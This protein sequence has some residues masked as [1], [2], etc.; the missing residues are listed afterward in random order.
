MDLTAISLVRVPCPA[1]VAVLGWLGLGACAPT[2]DVS[3]VDASH[4]LRQADGLALASVSLGEGTTCAA[5]AT[6]EAKCWGRNDDGRLG[7]GPSSSVVEA[8][9][10]LLPFLAVGGDV[11]AIATNGPHGYALLDDGSVVV[12]GVDPSGAFGAPGEPEGTPGSGV[13]VPL[14]GPAEQVVAGEGFGCARLSDARVQCWG[15][16]D[17]GQLGRGALPG[18]H[19]PADVLLGGVAVELA[20]GL[21]HACARL[22]TGAVRCWGRDHE[23]QL[24]YGAPATGAPVPSERGD[25]S[26]GG[27][28]ARIVAGAHHSCA[29][30]DTGSLRCWGDDT[31]GQL[32]LGSTQP[33]GDDELPS[34]VPEVELGAAVVDVAAGRH[35][36][37]A[38]LDD[39]SLR[40]WG[41]DGHQQLGSSMG[42]SDPA[43]PPGIVEVAMGGDAAEGVLAGALADHTCARLLGGTLRCWGRNDYGQLGLGFVDPDDPAEGP[44]GDL[45]D[46]I[47]VEDPDV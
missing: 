38:I 3:D 14:A 45:P 7:L 4:G 44:P 34:D 6:G 33:I 24:G 15:E 1:A 35:H 12:L 42:G 43:P 25:V 22:D 16:G 46:V 10:A 41:D 18:I 19:G 36:T 39:G 9:P 27:V 40:C 23:G 29:L 5:L 26:I 32:G 2:T 13:A 21:A 31:A 28:A 11:T 30:L 37:C 17:E 8:E 20:A 47:I